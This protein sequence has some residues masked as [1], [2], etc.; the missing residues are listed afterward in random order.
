MNAPFK[1]DARLGR[2]TTALGTDVLV[3]LRFD[4]ADYVNGLF[5]Y[6]VEALSTSPNLDF[7]GLLGTHASVEIESQNDG[8]RAYD[9]IATEAKWAGVGENGNKYALTLRPWFWLA[10]RRR[11]QRIFHNKTVV[12]IIEELLKPYSGLGDPALQVKLSGDYP[13]LEYTVQYRESD[14]DFATRLMERFGISYHFVH[15]VG[16]HTLV[17]T[18][19]IDQHDAVPGG[20]RD[21]KPVDGAQQAGAEYF[22]EWHPERRLTTGAVRLTD[23]NF[24]TPQAA[25]EVDRI[26][27][28]AHAEGQIES[29]DYPGEYLEQ[30]AGKGVV[31]LRTLQERGQ[32][33]RHRAVGDCTSLGAG[34]VLTLTGDQ[35]NGVK[36][37]DYLCLVA[38]HSYVSDAY[39]SGGADSDGYAYSGEY[40]LMPKEAPLAPERKTRMPVVQG[41]QTGVVVGE[42]EID[43]DEYGRILVH[44]HWDLDKSYSMRCRVSQN[45][46]S[47]GWGGMVIPRIGMEVVVEFLEGDPDKPLV[48]GC[49]YN[50]KND[51][52]YSLP[53]HKTRSTFRTDTHQGDGYNEL[54]FEDQNGKEEIF[55]HAQKD[56]NEK[57]LNNHTERVDHHYVQSV[58]A[59]SITEVDENEFTVVAKHRSVYVGRNGVGTNITPNQKS[60]EQGLASTP[61]GLKAVD[62]L[63]GSE[64]GLT[65]TVE[66]HETRAVGSS[67]ATSVGEQD[68]LNVGKKLNISVGEVINMSA[69]KE[70]NL[71]C[72]RSVLT[73]KR[74]GTIFL[75]GVKINIVADTRIN[76]QSDVVE[77]N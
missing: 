40:V 52:P 58:G 63:R 8:A 45:W 1:Q 64:G 22:W 38:N 11:N 28:A 14:L 27:D 26:G 41:P 31:G 25:M 57:T 35:V 33:A 77:I 21:Y 49:V 32:D 29:Y 55:V 71:H 5:E 50:G 47:Q 23:Y 39:G 59:N 6:R 34:M 74:D 13:V 9:G 30:G 61:I 72:G 70:I 12:Q 4:G 54:R 56:R 17:L 66:Q 42:G 16:N 19:A 48:T 67:R 76:I 36:G 15:S 60:A 69:G 10:G 3:L 44:F 51:A 65:T 43:C 20:K 75:N 24:K 7:D 18:D 68:H 46:A 2:L 53:D 62:T 73:M 37:A